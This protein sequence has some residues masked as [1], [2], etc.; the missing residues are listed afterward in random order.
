VQDDVTILITDN[1]SG[2]FVKIQSPVAGE[3]LT[4]NAPS[5]QFEY[6]LGHGKT[7]KATATIQ[8]VNDLGHFSD[9]LLTVH[10]LFCL[11]S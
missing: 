6:D 3:S 9:D 1:G 11:S 2:L 10:G 4:H 8:Q 5:I 7:L